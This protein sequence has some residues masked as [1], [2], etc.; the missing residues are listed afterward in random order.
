MDKKKLFAWGLILAVAIL[1]ALVIIFPTALGISGSKDD[2]GNAAAS[3][4]SL[5]QPE[6]VAQEFYNWYLA[7]FGDPGTDTFRNPIRDKAYHDSQYLTSSFIK[8][9]DEMVVSFGEHGGYDVFLCAQDIPD[10]MIAESAF[11]HG[12]QASVLMRS[13]IMGHFVVLD[14]QKVGQEWKIGNVTCAFS[15]E[16]VAKAFYT[17]YLGYI[18]DPA[19]DNL[20]NPLVDKAYRDSGFLSERFV[21]ELDSVTAAA[22]SADPILMAQDIPQDFS[23]DP[24]S[25][26]ETAIVHLQF[27]TDTVRHLK[28]QMIPDLGSWKINSITAVP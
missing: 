11:A 22:I 12:E 15:P 4:P 20:R 3:H 7:Y 19:S 9:V 2:Q 26:P 27:G 23:V 17:W 14:M 25:E 28:V 6:D 21:Q 5:Q 8:H 16:G 18:G 1:T 10:H 13:S 24:G